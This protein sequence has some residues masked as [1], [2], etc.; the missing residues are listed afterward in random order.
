MNAPVFVLLG[1]LC[2]SVPVGFLVGKRKGINI[3]ERGS[4]NIGFSNSLRIMGWKPGLLVLFGDVLKGYF[5]AAVAMHHFGLSNTALFVSFAAVLGHVFS[6]WLRFKGG[7]GV[8]TMMGVSLALCYPVALIAAAAWLVIFFTWRTASIGSLAIP[9]L[10][11]AI[12]YWLEPRLIGF[13][14]A[15]I[16]LLLYSLRPN[17]LRL[18]EGR[19]PKIA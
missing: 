13:Y 16:A 15:V 9:V 11:L 14:V 2:G 5:P 7:K 3:Q 4:G 6:P 18:I 19:E 12:V 8:A 10:I 1:F 17:I